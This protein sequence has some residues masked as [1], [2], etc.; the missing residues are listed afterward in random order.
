MAKSVEVVVRNIIEFEVDDDFEMSNYD[1][2]NFIALA[3]RAMMEIPQSAL[4]NDA[5]YKVRR[6]T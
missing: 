6:H 1:M 3:R 4:M 2:E 5:R